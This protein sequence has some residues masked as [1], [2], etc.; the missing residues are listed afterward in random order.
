MSSQDSWRADIGYAEHQ[1]PASPAGLD[2]GRTYWEASGVPP[3]KA[4]RP[5][6]HQ[7][8]RDDQGREF[9]ECSASRRAVLLREYL[10]GRI[11]YIQALSGSKRTDALSEPSWH[12]PRSGPAVT[13]MVDPAEV[14]RWMRGD[15]LEVP[16]PLEASGPAVDHAAG[17]SRMWDA[18]RTV[19]ANAEVP[20]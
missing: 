6:E 3:V 14:W 9:N 18:Y 2:G 17:S 19:L 1:T 20:F 4:P 15:E 8:V 12:P 10:R 5:G 16:P 13:P 7:R 11:R